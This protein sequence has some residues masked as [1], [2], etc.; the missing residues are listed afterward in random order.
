MTTGGEKM[1]ACHFSDF[2]YINLATE[3]GEHLAVRKHKKPQFEFCQPL[4]QRY[5]V[6]SERYIQNVRK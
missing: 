6:C 3:Q 1:L 5:I 4:C 2:R